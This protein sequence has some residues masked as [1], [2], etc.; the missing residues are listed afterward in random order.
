MNYEVFQPS[1][2]YNL[3]STWTGLPVEFG[4]SVH[5]ECQPGHFFEVNRDE[6][7]F[8]VRCD[9]A[10]TGDWEEPRSWLQCVETVHCG[11]P[12]IKHERGE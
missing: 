4:S 12:P 8:E 5:Y 6:V 11:Q 1:P 9:L 3:A 2:R 10:G 7:S